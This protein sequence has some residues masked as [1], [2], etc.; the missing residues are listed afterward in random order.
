MNKIDL[1]QKVKE[2]CN[3]SKQEAREIVEI[4]F[5]KMMVAFKRGERVEIR[6]FCSFNIKDYKSYAGHNPKTGKK[7]TIPAKKLPF[8]RCG[9]ELRERVNG[10]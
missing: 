6:G 5:T 10:A 7:V 4:F 9:K 1:I 2:K 3:L 8:F